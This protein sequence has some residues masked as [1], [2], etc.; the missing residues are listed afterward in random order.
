MKITSNIFICL[1]V[2]VV[3][4]LLIDYF[5]IK[6]YKVVKLK[7]DLINNYYS[8]EN[9]E[10][11]M[12]EKLDK[13]YTGIIEDDFDSF[14]IKLVM[15][16]LNTLE[17]E[18]YKRYNSFLPSDFMNEYYETRAEDASDFISKEL[19]DDIYYICFNRFVDG[20]SYKKFEDC[21]EDMSN[22]E[23]LIIDLRGNSGG[24]FKDLD[25]IIDTFIAKD[26]VIYK[27]YSN[28][29]TKEILTKNDKKLEF[30]NIII[31]TNGNTASTSELFVLALKNNLE[32]VN[33]VGT[34]TYGKNISYSIRNFKDESAMVF[35]SSI[36]QDS[37][38]ESIDVNGIIPDVIIGNSE[39]YYESIL[40]IEERDS[41]RNE[42]YE[43][44]LKYSIDLIKQEIN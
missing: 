9:L 34:R 30:R 22:Y 18:K 8:S 17:P 28:K 4:L 13:D 24:N 40:D 12:K 1:I 43:K 6:D 35:I 38:G 41:I 39:E 32:A 15:D 3:T 7:D 16:E 2:V 27:L 36:M 20:I 21:M 11:L 14:V 44:Q 23:N 5:R 29:K 42:D 19:D 26:R 37:N 10:F 33:I 25:K 31:L